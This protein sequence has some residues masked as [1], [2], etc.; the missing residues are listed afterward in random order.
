MM[1]L[2]QSTSSILGAIILL[3]IQYTTIVNAQTTNEPSISQAPT[4]LSQSPSTHPTHST[5]PSSSPTN[6]YKP[7]T[8]SLPS[9]S[10]APSDRMQFDTTTNATELVNNLISTTGE[11]AVEIS[12]VQASSHIESCAA[13]FRRGHT[14]GTLYQKGPAPNYDLLKDANGN[15]IP[16]NPEVYMVPDEGLILSSGS[17]QHLNTNDEDDQTTI[18]SKGGD[19]DLKKTVDDSNGINNSVFDACVLQFDFRCN[20]PWEGGSYVPRIEFNY[21]FGSEEYYEY[22][23]SEFNDVFGFYL[24]GNNIA[25]LPTT[26]TGSDVV[27]INNV[28]YHSN[29]QY[30]HGNDPG[31]GWQQD[32]T[33]DPNGNPV[34]TEVVY[35]TIEMD[36]FTDTLTAIGIPKSDVNEWN[37]IKLA[38]GDVGDNILDSWVILESASFT[39]VDVTQSPSVSL[40]PSIGKYIWPAGMSFDT[41]LVDILIYTHPPSFQSLHSIHS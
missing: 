14:L 5:I 13:L 17:P 35:P 31:T 1:S 39:C 7:S 11:I 33:E 34:I 40:A 27:S 26:N 36:G 25:K 41:R 9:L 4:I 2:Q 37:T 23:F 19:I 15:Y 24:N 28:N 38:V 29:K 6:S 22:V 20:S 21:I 10:S 16:T 18:H 30:F 12:N 8:T 32:P 3:A